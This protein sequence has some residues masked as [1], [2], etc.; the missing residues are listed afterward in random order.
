MPAPA[1]HVLPWAEQLNAAIFERLVAVGHEQ[2]GTEGV[3]FTQP[4]AGGAHSLRTVE[5]KKL[6][7]WWL[8]ADAAMGAGIVGRKL[9]VARL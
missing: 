4:V 3:L 9:N 2:V 8:K 6:R 5:A 1:S 7:A